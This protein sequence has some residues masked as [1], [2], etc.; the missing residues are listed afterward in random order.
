VIYRLRVGDQAGASPAVGKRFS[1]LARPP[2]YS[3]SDVGPAASHG[4]EWT[5]PAYMERPGQSWRKAVGFGQRVAIPARSF[6]CFF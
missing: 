3:S 6:A 5:R 4:G 2:P 1:T